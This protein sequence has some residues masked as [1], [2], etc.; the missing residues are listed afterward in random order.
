LGQPPPAAAP[1]QQQLV[2]ATISASIS[3]TAPT[4]VITSGAITVNI[5]S[6]NIIEVTNS[7]TSISSE[8]TWSHFNIYRSGVTVSSLVGSGL[9][10]TSPSGALTASMGATGLSV[11]GLNV[12]GARQT[13]P[14]NTSDVTDVAA[15]FNNLLT[16]LRNH[17][18]IT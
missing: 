2:C 5:D 16:A 14:G 6:T 10:L 12:V 15:R 7:S 13:G 11:Q 1:T 3:M 17:G 4:L 18:L 8:H 9:T